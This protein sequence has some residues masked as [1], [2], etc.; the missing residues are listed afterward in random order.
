MDRI[1]QYRAHLQQM[2]DWESFLLAESRLPGPRANLELARAAAEEGGADQFYRWLEFGPA[3]APTNT[4]AEFLPFCGV[5]GLG[6]MLVAGD[7][8][9][10]PQLKDAAEDPRWRVREAVVMALQMWGTDDMSSFQ[11]EMDEWVTGSRYHQR[12][13]VAA[14]CEPSL[15]RDV[16]SA[17]RALRLIDMVTR[18][19]ATAIDRRAA[20]FVALKKALG[21]CWSV[22]IVAAPV[23]GKIL[24]EKWSVV[25]DR[26]IRWV[27]RENLSKT[28][29]K[30]IDAEWASHLSGNISLGT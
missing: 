3:T 10:L 7:R 5:L 21:Y 4:P 15:L 27:V 19:F 25:A 28:R 16:E 26:D 18:S 30:K 29:L 8:Q 1:A 23:E 6:Q 9:V 22:A 12:A 17:G 14:V 13:A 2:C 24:F 20:G 11:A